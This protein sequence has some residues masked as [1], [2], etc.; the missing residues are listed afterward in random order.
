MSLHRCLLGSALW[1]L[2]SAAIA[3]TP[4]A[5]PTERSPLE[6]LRRRYTDAVFLEGEA[7]LSAAAA[8]GR[9]LWYKATG[10]NARF[11]SELGPKL[12]FA[13]D[14]LR[15]LRADRRSER[16]RGWG[17]VNDPSCCVPGTAGCAAKTLAETYGFDWCAGDDELLRY[18]GKEGYV[19]PACKFREGDSVAATTHES[20]CEL[21]FGTSAGA[22][23]FRKFPN[24][25]FDAE[26][27]RQHSSASRMQ[28]DSYP[29]RPIEERVEPPFLIGIA[30][31][32]C[33]VGFDPL[34]PPRD[35]AQPNWDNLRATAGNQY[36]RFG[37]ILATGLP[38]G[39]LRHTLLSF[40]E[41]GTVDT[42]LIEDDH[43][44][45]PSSINAVINLAQRPH[46]DGQLALM[47]GGEDGT[48]LRDSIR[49]VYLSMGVCAEPCLIEH[50]EDPRQFDPAA[51]RYRQT[52]VNVAQ[53]RN[54]CAAFRALDDRA[55][56]LAEFL[57]SR[58]AQ[59]TDLRAAR[60]QMRRRDDPAASYDDAQFTAQLEREFGAGA[61]QRGRRV[62]ARHCARC[63]SSESGFRAPSYDFR[64]LDA[65]TGARR[66]W[67]GN[68][69][70]S[71]DVEIGTNACRALHSNHLAGHIWAPF[72]SAVY[73]QRGRGYYRNVSLLSSWAHAPFMHNNAI[74][75]ALCRYPQRKRCWAYDPSVEGRFRLYK[76]SMRE[77]L[78]AARPVKIPRL[79]RDIR[80]PLD[81]SSTAELQAR[82][83][84]I[85]K[86]SSEVLFGSFDFRA[87]AADL[88]ATVHDSSALRETLIQR[89]GERRAI[90]LWRA[91]RRL[92]QQ[93]GTSVR[94]DL[95]HP[96]YQPYRNCE[97]Q[98]IN[99]GHRFGASL[100][101]AEKKALIAFVATL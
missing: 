17:L 98:I 91:L 59:P 100:S 97:D 49:R 5:V 61:V 73:R 35:A 53:C 27:W 67:L 81:G 38:A 93:G 10:G 16:F 1:V 62:F 43:I 76:A 54:D 14:W 88:A 29:A 69:K 57:H 51:S 83:L 34:N 40:G 70:P 42:S 63:H 58:D 24:P 86:G 80:V 56:A 20:A 50:L 90:D 37:A 9:E 23:G 87:L 89:H 92:V 71:R 95:A 52:P 41:A 7:G 3:Q 78:S 22:V 101:A 44:A 96:A 60:E 31:A 94:I 48:G 18:V 45:N 82:R 55:E 21:A 74:G 47:K 8:A 28:W 85:P 68:D 6:D 2:A 33:H 12:G 72:A 26:A 4:E 79:E 11:H 32:A 99:A 75:P 19:D 77:L 15:V 64:E 25:R 13:V 36:L 39:S 65:A 84:V 46:I 66:D 30:C